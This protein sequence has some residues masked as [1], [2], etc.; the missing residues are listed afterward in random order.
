MARLP[1]R[2]LVAL[3]DRVESDEG[4]ELLR[5]G[6]VGC[7]LNSTPAS[8]LARA[9]LE[10]AGGGALLA[11]RIAR[12]VIARLHR[13]QEAAPLSPREREVLGMLAR[14]FSYREI[15]NGLA[16]TRSTVESH[17]KS[18]YRKLEVCTK[19]EAAL[20]AVRRGIL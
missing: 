16:V 3:V 15:G 7:L 6:A 17:I 4:F 19:A 1:A 12:S 18:I 14:G 13:P 11:P 10:A 20:E 2:D 8:G 9:L 5:H